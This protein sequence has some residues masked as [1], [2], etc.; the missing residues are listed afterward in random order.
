MGRCHRRNSFCRRYGG[1]KYFDWRREPTLHPRFFDILK[2]CMERFDNVWMATNG[3]NTNAMLRLSNIIDN[4]DY[5]NHV[6]NCGC[7][8]SDNCSC[9]YSDTIFNDD[10]KLTVE[11]SLDQFHDPID[12]RIKTLWRRKAEQHK[13]SGYGV[14]SVAFDRLS[15]T[16]RAK[17]RLAL[18]F[19]HCVCNG[20]IIKPTGKIRL[21]GCTRSPVI[22]NI[23]DG[24]TEEYQ[25]IMYNDDGYQG[26]QCYR[27]INNHTI[28]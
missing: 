12:D 10:N 21:C 19:D 20:L 17:T 24:I 14:R 11:L 15:G 28:D 23:W 16:G 1:R 27:D 13:T 4:F 3:S 26:T 2:L 5:D 9:D 18:D 25:E 6:C 7:D 8:D 22:G